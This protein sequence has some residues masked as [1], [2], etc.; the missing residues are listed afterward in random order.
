MFPPEAFPAKVRS[1]FASDNAQYSRQQS[2]KKKAAQAAFF[3]CWATSSHVTKKV[4]AGEMTCFRLAWGLTCHYCRAAIRV[5]AKLDIVLMRGT[6]Q[7]R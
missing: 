6:A 7:D 5:Q 3:M 2:F 4:Q 1:G